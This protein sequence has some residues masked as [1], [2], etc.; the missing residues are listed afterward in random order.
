M[1][2]S[3]SS[4][5]CCTISFG[6]DAP[7]RNEKLVVTASSAYE[8]SASGNARGR[9]MSGAFLFS[10]SGM[11]I[12]CKQ[13]VDEPAR[14]AGLARVNPFAIKPEP[15][16]RL[17]LDNVIIARRMLL[18]VAPPFGGDALRPL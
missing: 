1:A 17:I 15:P 14:R 11:A 13:A 7:R 5:A 6:C 3:P 8:I 18:V 16:P 4:L 9:W 10:W 12:S 2:A